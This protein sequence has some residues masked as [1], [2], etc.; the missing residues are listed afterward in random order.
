M[1]VVPALLEP[2]LWWRLTNTKTPNKQEK[3]QVV[4][5]ASEREL[6]Q[7]NVNDWVTP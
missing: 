3:Y 7:S 4:I 2:A 5:S 1:G 6:K